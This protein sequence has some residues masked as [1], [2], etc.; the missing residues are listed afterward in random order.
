M[1]PGGPLEKMTFKLNKT[2]DGWGL[3]ISQLSVLQRGRWEEEDK[4]VSAGGRR[5]GLRDHGKAFGFHPQ[6]RD[7]SEKDSKQGQVTEDLFASQKGSH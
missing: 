4:Q 7:R 3:H 6:C 2:K 5:Q 1:E